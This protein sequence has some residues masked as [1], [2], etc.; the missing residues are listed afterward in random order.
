MLVS[1]RI[2]LTRDTERKI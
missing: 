1:D 2:A